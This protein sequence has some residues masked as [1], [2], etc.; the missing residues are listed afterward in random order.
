MFFKYLNLFCIASMSW[1]MNVDAGPVF[2]LDNGTL[3]KFIGE[4]SP[5]IIGSGNHWVDY[6]SGHK[7][8]LAV[9]ENG[10]L[11]SWG[12][13]NF[14]QLGRSGA[15]ESL[16]PVD[17]AG[18][19]NVVGCYAGAY[20]SFA[21]DASGNAY[22]WGR[23][24]F[25]QLGDGS[26]ISKN[27]PVQVP[28]NEPFVDIAAGADHTLALGVSGNLYVF[29]SHG[30]HQT[31]S[32]NTMTPTLIGAP[33]A[34][35][36]IAAGDFHSGA[37]DANGNVYLWGKNINGQAG[38]TGNPTVSMPT[39]L[40]TGSWKDLQLGGD[41][42]LALTSGGN[43]MGRGDSSFAQLGLE[44]NS[45]G[46][47]G[48]ANVQQHK[49]WKQIQA[50][51]FSIIGEDVGGNIL[52]WG[53]NRDGWL[54]GSSREIEAAPSLLLEAEPWSNTLLYDYQL[55]LVDQRVSY[56]SADQINAIKESDSITFQQNYHSFTSIAANVNVI[57][58]GS[59]ALFWGN[60]MAA[61]S[62]HNG[63]TTANTLLQ[64]VSDNAMQ[65]TVITTFQA[66]LDHLRVEYGVDISP[67]VSPEDGLNYRT[68]IYFTGTGMW[69]GDTPVSGGGTRIRGWNEDTF[70][71]VD[72]PIIE[73]H[74]SML[75]DLA[76]GNSNYTLMHEMIHTLQAF[77]QR[78]NLQGWD[79]YVEGLASYFAN[80][81]FNSNIFSMEFENRRHVPIDDLAVRYATTP[82]WLSL[83]HEFGS[84]YIGD[85]LMRQVNAGESLLEFLARIAPFSNNESDRRTA[86]A[87][88]M[89]RYA[90]GSLHYVGPSQDQGVDISAQI[91][92]ADRRLR[93][94][95][96][97]HQ[98]G[99]QRYRVADALAPGR[100]GRNF[101]QLVRDPRR[102]VIEIGFKGWAVPERESQFRVILVATLN[103]Q[104]SPALEAWGE[105]FRGGTQVVNVK[106]WEQKLGQNIQKLTLV[107]IA[108]PL[109]WM[110]QDQLFGLTEV[111]QRRILDRYVYEV[112]IHGAWPVGHEPESLRAPVGV[113][114]AAHPNGGGFVANTAI[115]DATAYVGPKARVLG[116][117]QVRNAARIEGRAFIH[118]S[119]I[120]SGNAV[121]SGRSEIFDTATVSSNA[122]VRD[123]NLV[124][125]SAHIK[126]GSLIVGNSIYY[127]TFTASGNA[128]VMGAP[129]L[130]NIGLANGV[131]GEAVVDGTRWFGSSANMGTPKDN[132]AV[133]GHG[134]FAHY[135]FEQQHPYRVR[136]QHASSDAYILSGNGQ[137]LGYVPQLF[138]GITSSNTL[139]LQGSSYLELPRHLL[140]FHNL[141]I[142]LRLKWNGVSTEPLLEAQ[143]ELGEYFKITLEPGTVSSLDLQFSH[144]DRQGAVS[145]A[146]LV[147]ANLNAGEWLI[148]R[149]SFNGDQRSLNLAALDLNRNTLVTSDSILSS[150]LRGLHM[151]SLRF[152]LGFSEE[153]GTFLHAQVDEIKFSRTWDPY[154]DLGPLTWSNNLL[155]NYQLPLVDQKTAYISANLINSMK[156][157]DPITFQPNYHSFSSIAANVN[158]I[159]VGSYALYWG[160]DMTALATH[161]GGTTA[162]TLLQL[163][164]DNA[165]QQTVINTFQAMLDH[166]R[167]KYGVDISPSV[168]PENGLNYRTAI[169]FTGTGMWA[170]DTPNPVGLL[171]MRGWNEDTTNTVDTPIIEVH[172]AL[173]ANI[174]L[175]YSNYE[176]LMFYVIQAMQ[177]FAQRNQVHGWDWYV[178]GLPHYFNYD[179]FNSSV[180]LIEFENRRHLPIDDLA[181]KASTPFWF[182]LGHEFGNKYIGDIL[183]RQVNQGE[184]L[185]EFLARI[186]P[187]S[188][189]DSERRA[190]FAN[191]MGRYAAGSLNYVG[192]SRDRGVN[193]PAQLYHVDR[194]LRESIDLQ[195][196]SEQRY[197]V[198]DALAPGR[199]GRNFIQLVRDPTQDV[200]EIGF[201]GWDVPERESQFR[202]T[203]VATL[204]DQ[205]SPASEAWGEMFSSG[206]QVVNIKNW[207]QKLGQKIQKLTLV[208]IATPLNWMEQDQLFGLTEVE[209][210][211]I[212][213]RYVY[214]VDIHGA[215]PVGHEPEQFR[216]P[217]GVS[218]A[219]HPN[220]GGFVANTAT[221]ESSAY[222]GP[223]A[224]VLGNAQVRNAARIEG[225]AVI[226]GSAIVSG[227]AVISGRSELFD[228]ATLS[229]NAAIRDSNLVQYSAHI[230]DGSLIVGNSI[231]YNSFTASDNAVVMGAPHLWNIG[232]SSGVSGEAIAD[233]TRWFG[234]S[235]SMGTPKD[236]W[237][238]SGNGLFAYY[239]F[240]QQHPYRVRD[241][242]ASSDAYILSGNGQPLGYVPQLFD[243]TTSSNTLHLQGSSYLELP[244]HL[245]DFHNLSINLRLKWNGNSNEPLL[246]AQSELN[247]HFKIILVPGSVG[248]L[249]I[250]FS[251]RYRQ[252][253]VS[254]AT[255]VG[256]GLNAGQWIDLRLSFKGDQRSLNIEAF[257]LNGNTLA[258]SSTTLTG[259]LRELHMDSL[260]FWLG[261]SKESGTYLHAQL[262]EIKFWRN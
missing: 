130:W 249:D 222:V 95:I 156:E 171:R 35:T 221:V 79:W 232:A 152:R 230:T 259:S 114:G 195:L 45:Q 161:N 92:H 21:L 87:N 123:S 228:T 166:L 227:N 107:V 188:N 103:D 14:G 192:P 174:A 144:R 113:S 134:L 86:F 60:D 115:V 247:E 119:A 12:H 241:Q 83:R 229:S 224:R 135:N 136:D 70:N 34:W 253:A 66:M 213:D 163:V 258:S 240:E 72:T 223:K 214:E 1:S 33:G 261:F 89:G 203:L 110:A 75:A 22:A 109:N 71:T 6:S 106:N 9:D 74:G 10:V 160:N 132:W 242:H 101:I 207:E 250:Q 206:N 170:G 31:H 61:I 117:A 17:F 205:A 90:A 172:G 100:F 133:S 137:P 164:S 151:D 69:V 102:D 41:Y 93:E 44:N 212:L 80:E 256:A 193:I 145:T 243:G 254:T 124:Q 76:M 126:D 142:E 94:S 175:G 125:Y 153:T 148:F 88:A 18:S 104:V 182:S 225:R 32:S 97:L 208:V 50:R 96:D 40:E 63:G 252:G 105:M 197:R 177:G 139:H 260:R 176:S 111:E 189:P 118:G 204:N 220:G 43:L 42:S 138:D 210:R 159:N 198:A 190:A 216:A 84:A 26:A 13:N 77:A 3:V 186:S 54:V 191:A 29:G 11:Y 47:S 146:T 185:L 129:H 2:L 56:I 168:S 99:K 28:A 244:R 27:I 59:Y 162:N 128:V 57:N 237:I 39:L 169:Y 64:L 51:R 120:V 239:N 154:F 98:V 112:D 257:D 16:E 147:G 52:G 196:V 209:Q 200:I 82:F 217:I 178:G 262:D 8:H 127:E 184:S 5:E 91:Y 155:N 194:R 78:N 199:F 234:S 246:E 62:S 53:D 245:L 23:N 183:M 30:F 218:G 211:R 231:Y 157:S 141:S 24:H 48:M 85:I 4:G 255:L 226:H 235:A 158:V 116:N 108:T 180:S 248:S 131:S 38:T 36:H 49:K 187:F 19:G 181:F 25:G 219:A 37:I 58:V 140:D 55:P 251:H 233:G 7:H 215:W 46:I 65:Q 122:A 150:T 236:N 15:M 143:S 173:L 149:L 121:V 165:M 81:Y 202:V 68:A 201:K 167:V 73:V 67:S 238:I 20:H 179:Y